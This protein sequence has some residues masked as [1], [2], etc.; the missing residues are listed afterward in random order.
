MLGIVSNGHAASSSSIKPSASIHSRAGN[1]SELLGVG[2]HI[3][4]VVGDRPSIRLVHARL[5]QQLASQGIERGGMPELVET[6][7]NQPIE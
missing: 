1:R 3:L 4:G 5:G 2:L 7:D 6:L